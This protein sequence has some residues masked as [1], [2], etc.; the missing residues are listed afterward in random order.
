VLDIEYGCWYCGA[1]PCQLI[2]RLVSAD[3]YSW[4]QLSGKVE[5]LSEARNTA[6]RKYTSR[7]DEHSSSGHK[8]H[9]FI[10][11]LHNHAS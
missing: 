10:A 1:A 9:A 11:C 7:R 6:R 3:S 2:P 5:R 4:R 8:A